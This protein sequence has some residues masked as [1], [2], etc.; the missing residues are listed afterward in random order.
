[1]AV[2][3]ESLSL[4]AAIE[5]LG[6]ATAFARRGAAQAGLPGERL[7]VVDLVVE[8][9]FANV[10]RYSYPAGTAG[11]VDMVWSVPK[12]GL[13]SIEMSDLGLPFDPLSRDE[14]LLSDSLH[15]R[16]IGGLG[17]FLIR[18]LTSSL[19]YRRDGGRNRVRF[20]ISASSDD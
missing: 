4:T 2:P 12:P 7:G 16:P 19:T 17:V 18:Q 1:M 13:L 5:F 9:L 20:E 10:A 3:S 15:D 14:P 6:P 8:E 11:V